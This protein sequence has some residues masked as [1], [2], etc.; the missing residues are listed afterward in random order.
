MING[1]NRN[2]DPPQE[3]RTRLPL[4]FEA[5]WGVRAT[6]LN[7]GRK[8]SDPALDPNNGASAWVFGAEGVAGD[9]LR[10]IRK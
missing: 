10:R 5:E 4:H 3:R 2:R 9:T 7:S 6:E 1:G 8:K